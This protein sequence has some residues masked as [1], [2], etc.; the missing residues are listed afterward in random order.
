M[1][2][3]VVT[4]PATGRK[5]KLTGDSP[6]TDQDLEEIF[7]NLPSPAS[8]QP[9][10]VA[11]PQSTPASHQQPSTEQAILA[12]SIEPSDPYR[13]AQV[14]AMGPGEQPLINPPKSITDKALAAGTEFISSVNRG[15]LD[16]AG[17]PSELIRI[18]VNAGLQ[19]AGVDYQIP[20]A[21]QAIQDVTGIG[22]GG[23]M[24]PGTARD[25]VQATGEAIP[26]SV[27]VGGALTG[28]ASRLPAI[29]QASEGVIP[30]VIRAAGQ[31]TPVK[32]VVY[33]A[34]GGGGSVAGKEVGQAVGGDVGGAIGKIVGGVA[35]PMIP[36]LASAAGR[37]VANAA[38]GARNQDA[39]RR[40]AEDF[41][42]F[43]AT[44]TA[45]IASGRPGLQATETVMGSAIGGSPISNA[46]ESIATAMQNKLKRIAGSISD[47]RGAEDA[48][49]V[50]QKGIT[51]RGGFIDRWKDNQSVLW[52]KADQLINPQ[53]PVDLNNTQQA[54][55]GIVQGGRFGSILDNP[56]LA[57][58]KQALDEG[59]TLQYDEVRKLR[60]QLGAML[61][62]PSLVADIPRGEVKRVHGALSEDIR[63]L[64]AN[65]GTE[66]AQAFN[67]ANTYTKSG[68][69]RIDDYLE[70][71]A[72]KVNP[73]EVFKAIAKGGEGVKRLN[74][75]KR[76]LKPEEWDVVASNVVSRLGR[77]S[78]GQQI[79]EGEQAAGDVFSIAKFATD[80]EKLG[81]A[82]KVLF[83]G[84][85]N[86]NKY[87]NDLN[88]IAR[89]AG[90]YKQAAAQGA[91]YS[92]TAQAG[93]RL[94][95]ASGLATSIFTGQPLVAAAVLGSIG[96]NYA[97]SSLMT[98]PRF[99]SIISKGIN[100]GVSPNSIAAQLSTL[101]KK[102]TAE[103]AA[104]IYNYLNDLDSEVNFNKEDAK[105]MIN[106]AIA[107]G[108]TFNSVW[109]NISNDKELSGR[110]K[111]TI[112]ENEFL[113]LS[114]ISDMEKGV[115]RAIGKPPQN[116]SSGS[117][118]K[119]LYS[120]DESSMKNVSAMISSPTFMKAAIEAARNP[121]AADAKALSA[122]LMKTKA[123]ND[124]MSAASA[125]A[126][127]QI[128]AAGG[129]PL[130]LMTKDDSEE[131][132]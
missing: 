18:P 17:L 24:E 77:A 106:Q 111:K 91:N 89:A 33:G 84:T 47:V 11:P 132:Q 79:A 8:P 29:A 71:I 68:H 39:S 69:E 44:P 46:R 123:A 121:T 112:G 67:R 31:S 96:S 122:Q 118:L 130:W 72:K 76:S 10:Q 49:L 97:A 66:A 127:K 50:V 41:A 52:G 99:V 4:D 93:A 82:R 80:W 55:G 9:T 61:S 120:G 26:A 19:A 53:G 125:D 87:A 6:P 101:A 131:Q 59:A 35:T 37:G 108:K 73:D 104:T 70:G 113:A 42:S 32:N 23:Y 128:I 92:G 95:A 58:I 3:Y 81:P 85:E 109:T 90:A 36:G 78:P 126:R 13:A 43:D 40:I 56:K 83:T 102:S 110:F 5:V 75:I 54:L 45:G 86:T 74:S 34:L 27:A 7:A 65:S 25:I 116:Y 12:D 28:A 124:F 114:K 107:E 30:G 88:A 64:A 60:S 115:S 62:N 1:P 22:R 105:A 119:K 63:V 16:I 117:I 48:G 21:S 20:R 2:T 15:A 14:R 57:Q 51:G 100:T 129:I 98:N 38:F 94:G 103:D